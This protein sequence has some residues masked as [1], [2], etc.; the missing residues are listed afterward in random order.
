[1]H[2]APNNAFVVR[3]SGVLRNVRFE[4]DPLDEFL[5]LECQLPRSARGM[6]RI[7]TQ[8]HQHSLGVLLRSRCTQQ[9]APARGDDG[10]APP[11]WLVSFE[12]R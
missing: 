6:A 7:V 5:E 8:F 3:P 10:A 4:S 2:S 11:P 12:K 9:V 1:V